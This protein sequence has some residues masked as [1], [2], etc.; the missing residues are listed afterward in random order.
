[1]KLLTSPM[2][3]ILVLGLAGMGSIVT[4]VHLL[5]GAGWATITGGIMAVSTAALIARGLNNG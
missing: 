4:G 3:Y 2:T 1:M 5:A